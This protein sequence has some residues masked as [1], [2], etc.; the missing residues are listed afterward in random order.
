MRNKE[1]VAEQVE[2]LLRDKVKLPEYSGFGDPNHKA[3]DAMIEVLK[4]AKNLEDDFQDPDD[5]DSEQEFFYIQSE[6]ERAEDWLEE[7][8]DEN[9][10]DDIN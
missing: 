9:L 4:G 5:F 1:Q 3:I 10:F 8:N 6:V 7:R 2:G